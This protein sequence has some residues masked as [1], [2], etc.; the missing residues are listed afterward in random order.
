VTGP[1]VTA[2]YPTAPLP[3]PDR[4]RPGAVGWTRTILIAVAVGV[5]FADS[6]IV[7]LAL[8]ELLSRFDTTITAVSWVVTSYNVTVAVLAL[9]LVPMMASRRGVAGRL[10]PVR[11]TQAGLVVFCAASL[12]CALAGDLGVLIGARAVQGAGAAMLLAGSV[13]LLAVVAG[14]PARGAAV[15]GIAGV[16]GA[17]VGPALG[18]ALTQVFDW[19][20]IFIAQ[21][22][23][24]AAALLATFRVEV[25]APAAAEGGG[26]ADRAIRLP[27]GAALALVSAALVGALFLSVVLMIDGWGHAP[28][29]AAAIVSALPAGALLAGPVVRR[30]APRV[31]VC[32]GIVLVG[33][34]LAAM[35][36]L[37]EPSLALLCLSLALCGL[38]LGLCMPA[39]TD[40]SLRGPSLAASGTWSVG[41][42]HVGLVLGL[43]LLTP[44][45]S[46]D[47]SDVA[48]RAQLA[49][50]SALIDAR[51]SI[52]EKVAV[53][54]ALEQ[55]ID[56]APAGEV[57][58]LAP[59][60][61]TGGDPADPARIALGE[62][63]EELI[64]ATITRGFRNAFIL[65]AVLAA[66][67]LVPVALLRRGSLR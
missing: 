16:M 49:G 59:A 61:A 2:Q 60:L 9:I 44:L 18:G 4:A 13:P 52:E 5:A 46:S 26:G 3:R 32:G 27:A 66:L 43:V 17:A 20:S 21:V 58:D 39:L 57:P 62:R 10:H 67:A 38:G 14:S 1:P 33:G 24:A 34:A 8:P 25:P 53:G 22:P 48:D 12:A 35:A 15:W 36:L 6:S 42:R 50:A 51:L 47:L 54:Q 65:C 45:L 41:A 37:P 19:R 7:V 63:L 64:S 31:A 28:L 56:T 23:L 11:L 29:L 30:S 55:A 40:A